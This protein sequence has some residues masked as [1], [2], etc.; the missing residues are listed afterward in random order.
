MDTWISLKLG[1]VY[2]CGF[3]KRCDIL[4]VLGTVS[5]Y[6]DPLVV[7]LFVQLLVL[8]LMLPHEEIGASLEP[9]VSLFLH[10]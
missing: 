3:L 4:F 1:T 6:L 7:F 10:W 9:W 2:R 5:S 8:L